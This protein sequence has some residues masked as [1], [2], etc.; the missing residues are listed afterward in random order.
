MIR[1]VPRVVVRAPPARVAVG[2]EVGV[3]EGVVVGVVVL[4][5][6]GGQ[7]H[8]Q[9]EREEEEEALEGEKMGLEGNTL[10]FA[11][12]DDFQRYEA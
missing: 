4:G 9:E 6:G 10:F 11:L 2:L 7:G 5:G 8:R 12:L 3:V 1:V